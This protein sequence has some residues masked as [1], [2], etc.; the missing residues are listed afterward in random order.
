MANETG[1]FVWHE[2]MTSDPSAAEGFYKD[3]VGWQTAPFDQS[4]TPYTMWL[5]GEQPVGG[6]MHIPDEAKE[7]GAP[8]NW[9]AYIDVDNVDKS[10]DKAK[11][12]GANVLQPPME[13]PGVGRF[14]V[15]KDPQGAVVAFY[16]GSNPRDPESDPKKQEFSWHEL[17]TSDPDGAW[18]FYSKVLGWSKKD[19]MDMGPMGTYQMFGRDRFTYG[20]IYRKPDD[21]PAPS[22]WLHY[23]L[24]DDADEAAK[25]A[26]A[27]GGKVLNGPMEVPGGDR[28]AVLMDPQGAAFAV[29]SKAKK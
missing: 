5:A 21:M 9:L 11:Q 19:A 6:L 27:R 24:V 18:D 3:V 12:L 2:L 17:A 15:I 23:A 8:P 4:P 28:I 25:R 13:I 1:R 16:K 29:H 22:H 26:E 7:M 14:S 10:V 20:G